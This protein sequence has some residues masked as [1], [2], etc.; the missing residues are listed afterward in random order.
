[1]HIRR[2][3]CENDVMNWCLFVWLTTDTF[4]PHEFFLSDDL[5]TTLFQIDQIR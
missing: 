2:K 5:H 4:S 3:R 1:M